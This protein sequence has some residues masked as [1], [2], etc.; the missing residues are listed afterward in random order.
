MTFLTI[1]VTITAKTGLFHEKV[2]LLL[3]YRP[4]APV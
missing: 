1:K 2:I 3:S 4:N